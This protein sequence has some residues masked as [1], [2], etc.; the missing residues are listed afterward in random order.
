MDK[1]LDKL[2][3]YFLYITLFLFPF[4]VIP[5]SP[6]PFVVP[7]IA[8]LLF[9]I[10][11]VILLKA[12]KTILRGRLEFSASV[13][14]FPVF[15]LGVSFILSAILRTPNKMEAFFLPGEATVGVLGTLVFFLI[16]Q[17][18][19]EDKRAIGMVLLGSGVVFSIISLFSFLGVFENIAFLPA[20]MKSRL[21][22]PEGSHFPSLIFLILVAIV[23][24]GTFLE[25]RQLAR[26]TLFGSAV[27]ILILGISVSLFNILPGKPYYPRFLSYRASWSIAVDSLKES[28]ILG[29]GPGNYLTAY[30]RYRPLAINQTDLWAVKFASAR[31]Y[32]LALFTESGM[33]GAAALIILLVAVFKFL[34]N[35]IKNKKLSQFKAIELGNIISLGLIIIFLALFPATIILKIIFFIL[36]AATTQTHPSSF[37]LTSHGLYED[38][39]LAKPASKLPAVLI[40]SPAILGSLILGY[41]AFRALL[42]EYKFQKAIDSLSTNQASATYDTLREATAI[43]PMVDR[44]HMLFARVNLALAN[45]IARKATASENP[46]KLSDQDQANISI[47]VQQSINE[48]KAGVTLNPLRSGNWE[49]LGQIYRSISPLAKGADNFALQTYN[50]AVALDPLNP[51]LRIALGGIYFNQGNYDTAVRVFELATA[52]KPDL[53]NAHFN[54]AVALREKGDLNRAISEITLA[55]SLVDKNSKDYDLAKRTLDDIQSKKASLP[56]KGSELSSPKE[57]QTTP[58]EPKLDLP[59]GSEPPETPVTPSPTGTEPTP[60]SYAS[61]T[62]TS[63]SAG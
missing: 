40:T 47:L 24:V 30:N 50:Q 62:P 43:N 53:A 52:A 7:K 23:G 12:L 14:D 60:S 6:N 51:N 11:S 33:L 58:L 61:P 21:F 31:S 39:S 3:K 63:G 8:I 38:T 48:A 56:E 32:Y 18:K 57:E 28:P 45:A 19:K 54:L 34:Q 13:F 4:F 15:L 27:F 59:E 26:R 41:L 1:I 17:L 35:E 9:G 49:A 16:N 42:A 46:Q 55:L 2:D 20:F 29:I 36:L 44:Y 22:N 10:L 5:I 37:S 25:E